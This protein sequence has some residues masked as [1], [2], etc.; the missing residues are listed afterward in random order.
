MSTTS[1]QTTSDR[2]LKQ[3]HHKPLRSKAS[4]WLDTDIP[5]VLQLNE[6]LKDDCENHTLPHSP[7]FLY[8]FA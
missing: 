6:Y 8:E 1:E 3:N 4:N 2:R 7:R 5:L